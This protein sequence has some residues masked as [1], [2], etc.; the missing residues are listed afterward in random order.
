MF[1]INKRI[2]WIDVLR[3]FTILLVLLG[4]NNPPFIKYIYGFHMPLFF[5]ISGYL[6]HDYRAS[7]HILKIIR[8]Y[9]LQY[10]LLCIFN[11]VL[12]EFIVML[13]T[14]SSF[15]NWM[16]IIDNIKG[17]LF[18]N[19]GDMVGCYPLWFLPILAISEI[20]FVLIM[21][22]K[23]TYVRIGLIVII[24]CVGF[25]YS[26][27]QLVIP[28]RPQ[29]ALVGVL[30]LGIGYY[31]KYLKV[32]ERE[33]AGLIRVV[34]AVVALALAIVGFIS[35][36]ANTPDGRVNMSAAEYGNIALFLLGAICWSYVIM[37]LFEVLVDSHSECGVFKALKFIGKHTIFIMAFDEMTNIL[38]GLIVE[39]AK[40]KHFWYTD[41]FIRMMVMIVC[42]A[43]Y[44]GLRK[45][46]EIVS[47]KYVGRKSN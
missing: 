15:M 26:N 23:N 7:D 41:F 6:Y 32:F 14:K 25:S 45:I 37:Y 34:R 16:E 47:G 39:D 36:E 12:Y 13:I 20:V 30:F 35:I 10:F 1:V 8:H 2:E 21:Q 24:A 44:M 40:I 22:F 28:L 33:Y 42:F 5:I 31:M 46:C 29:V 3:G 17:I 27:M 4:H 11:G 9:Y 43:V 18:V 19:S 38:G